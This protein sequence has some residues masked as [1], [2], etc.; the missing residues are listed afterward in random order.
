MTL[1]ASI[2][3]PASALLKLNKC[4][5]VGVTAMAIC[6]NTAHCRIATRDHRKSNY[7]V[8]EWIR[9]QIYLENEKFWCVEGSGIPTGMEMPLKR[10]E[11][12]KCRYPNSID[13][14]RITGSIQLVSKLGAPCMGNAQK[15]VKLHKV[16][17][18]DKPWF[19]MDVIQ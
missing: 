8:L 14:Q 9:N 11:L 6:L 1:T 18:N 15:I 13:V 10:F 16:T 2:P 12:V 19:S 7:L 17:S 5:D 4:H 3:I